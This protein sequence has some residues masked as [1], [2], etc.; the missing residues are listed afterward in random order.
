MGGMERPS[1]GIDEKFGTL[2]RS[3]RDVSA[4]KFPGAHPVH[5]AVPNGVTC[6]WLGRRASAPIRLG[7]SQPRTKRR[8]QA[9]VT[10]I[11]IDAYAIP[12]A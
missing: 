12:K 2:P 7:Q 3:F 8:L 9:I 4:A 10:Q 5:N 6:G 11:D 1:C